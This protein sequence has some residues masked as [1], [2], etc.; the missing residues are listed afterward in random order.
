MEPLQTATSRQFQIGDRVRYYCPIGGTG[1][2]ELN[3]FVGTV[4]D[5]KYD[6]LFCN[7]L[8]NVMFDDPAANRPKGHQCIAK[9]LT[10]V[11]EK[12]YE[13]ELLDL[14]CAG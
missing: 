4:V 6:D 3:E 14:L 7:H 5:I 10:P 11:V 9:N 13:N 8:Y 2:T 12:T 1:W